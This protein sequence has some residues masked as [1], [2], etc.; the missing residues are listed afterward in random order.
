[1]TNRA[2]TIIILLLVVLLLV[3]AIYAFLG[4][5]QLI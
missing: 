2:S 5:K 1:M 4:I 3:I